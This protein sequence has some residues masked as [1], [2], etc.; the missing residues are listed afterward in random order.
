MAQINFIL[1][2]EEIKELLQ[3][4]KSD[5]FRTLLENALNSFIKAESDEKLKALPYERSEERTD[6]R[7]GI[8]KRPLATRVGTITLHVPRHRNEPFHTMVYENYERTEQ[9]LI[10]TMA[11]MVVKGVATA[12]VSKVMETLCGKS[13]SKSSVS[14]ACKVL[15]EE[16]EKFKNRKI[17]KK[18]PFVIVDATY[19]KVRENH[20]VV[21][22]ALMVAIGINEEGIKEI[23]GFEAY[24]NES[25]ETWTEFLAKLKARG[26]S[27]VKLITSDA[28]NGILYAMMQ[29]FPKVPWQRC[30]FHF[31]RNILEKTPKSLKEGLKSE[32]KAMFTAPNLEL[33]TKRMNQISED[34]Q[35]VAEKAVDCLEKNFLDAMTCLSLPEKVRK[36]IR[37]SNCI[38]RLNRELKRRSTPLG[39]FPNE[40]SLI[41]LIGSVLIDEH[42]KWSEMRKIFYTPTIIEVNKSEKSLETLANQQHMLLKAS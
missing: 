5:A 26:L 11:E 42:E 13:F 7:N 38:E 35:D 8:R 10:L 31:M 30:Q 41:R 18:Y 19:F 4:D 24:D 20:R 17:D 16:V 15:D 29:L 37:T 6:S 39:I 28:H 40:D 12:K 32:L 2:H 36:Y 23:I 22:K 33:A 14:K 34:Y 9:A 1:N 21:S 3:T 25:K 27:G